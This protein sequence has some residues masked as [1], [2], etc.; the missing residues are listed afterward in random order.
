VRSILISNEIVDD[1]KDNK[2][3]NKKEKLEQNRFSLIDKIKSLLKTKI[4]SSSSSPSSFS[5]FTNDLDDIDPELIKPR[6]HH[7]RL[8]NAYVPINLCNIDAIISLGE[9]SAIVNPQ[10]IDGSISA[11]LNT[12]IY[13]HKEHNDRSAKLMEEV[14]SL[15]TDLDCDVNPGP[16]SDITPGIPPSAA[17]AFLEQNENITA[18]HI[19]AHC[20]WERSEENKDKK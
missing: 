13:V 14:V 15:G 6:A 12:K 3:T 2:T 10:L 7:K 8:S 16:G 19:C 17:G 18:I 5:T 11:D 9:F 4:P 20:M 1:V